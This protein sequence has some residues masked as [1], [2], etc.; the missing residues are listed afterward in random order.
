VPER[1]EQTALAEL[2]AEIVSAYVSCNQ[3]TPSDLG[4]LVSTVASEL[5]KVGTRLEQSAGS[6]PKPEPEGLCGAGHGERTP[7]RTNQRNGFRDRPWET[8][9][10]IFPNEAAIVRLVGPLLLEQNDEWAVGRRYMS[11]ET[12]AP[13]GHTEPFRLPAVAV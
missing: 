12:L 7:E 10:G 11:L 13:F 8:R 6:E 2:T 9:A 1:L 4:A 3:V 5:R